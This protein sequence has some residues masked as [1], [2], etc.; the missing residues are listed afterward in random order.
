M[1]YQIYSFSQ[2][3]YDELVYE[4][5]AD[6]SFT[7][8]FNHYIYFDYEVGDIS[9]DMP[10]PESGKAQIYG[11]VIYEQKPVEGL[12]LDVVLN[13][14]FKKEGLTTDAKG[15]FYLDV[16]EGDWT[17][18]ALLTN[19][20]K[21]KPEGDYIVLTE[22]EPSLTDSNYNRHNNRV[23][24]KVTVM[25]GDVSAAVK[26]TI[27][28]PIEVVTPKDEGEYDSSDDGLVSWGSVEGAETYV[29][30]M[31]EVERRK[32][33]STSSQIL[34]R[35]VQSNEISFSDIGVASLSDEQPQVYAIE[36]LAFDA[37][38]TLINRSPD[39]SRREF[40]ASGFKFVA[41]EA[42]LDLGD[43]FSH[44]NIEDY[45]A[46]QKRIKAAE[47]LISEKMFAPAETIISKITEHAPKGKKAALTGYLLAKKG[48]CEDAET[49]FE[50]ALSI[51]GKQCLPDAYRAK[52]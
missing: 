13:S 34:E 33:G 7:E 16:A 37:E 17:I 20:W 22:Y 28:K 49:Y 5:G 18:N 45:Y 3:D 43:S 27:V 12:K 29:L 8:H 44:D 11:E 35:R 10:E 41:D 47:V 23:S 4:T 36:I 40:I 6:T 52:C 51:A 21:N 50:K 46:N 42:K 30:N 14:E 38:G 15:R 48:L 2:M 25:D 1:A 24:P 19:S 31:Q 9:K 26:I 39:F 32:N